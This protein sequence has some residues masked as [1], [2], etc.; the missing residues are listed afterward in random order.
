[1]RAEYAKYQGD[2]RSKLAELQSTVLKAFGE[3]EQAMVAAKFLIAREQAI[4]EALKSAE[5]AAEDPASRRRDF[6]ENMKRDN[7]NMNPSGEVVIPDDLHD[8]EIWTVSTGDLERGSLRSS[9]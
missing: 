3:V 5:E 8:L 4:I 1:M 9:G 6:I 2:D 7:V